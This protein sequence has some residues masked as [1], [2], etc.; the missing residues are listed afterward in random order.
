[1]VRGELL[2]SAP[3]VGRTIEDC[4]GGDQGVEV[5]ANLAESM[6]HHIRAGS[7]SL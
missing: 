6:T 2:K 5:L 4:L 7:R 3:G 1:M